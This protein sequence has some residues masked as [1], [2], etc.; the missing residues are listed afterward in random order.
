VSEAYTQVPVVL[1]STKSSPHEEFSN[2]QRPVIKYHTR[3]LHSMSL[4]VIIIS[5][6][7]CPPCWY[8]WL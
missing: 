4:M 5:R 1:K 2:L 3:T 7:L 6:V 8:C